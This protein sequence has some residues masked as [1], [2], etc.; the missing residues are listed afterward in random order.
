LTTTRTASPPTTG[1]LLVAHGSSEDPAASLPVR[2]LGLELR[3]SGRFAQVA[4]GFW[5]EWPGLRGAL[6]GLS[7]DRAV[8]VPVFM[9]KGWFTTH[10]VPRELGLDVA[11]ANR[12]GP[13]EVRVTR[14]IGASE[15]MSELVEA[16]ALE[17]LGEAASQAAVVVAG[18]GTARSPRSGDSVRQV[19]EALRHRGRFG[20]VE[21][22]F[23]E[24]APGL[25]EV[26]GALEADR[27]LVVPF[28][29]ADGPH[30]AI[31]MA[32]AIGLPAHPDDQPIPVG[33]RTMWL[34]P[35]VG[36][37]QCIADLVIKLVTDAIGE[38]LAHNTT[39]RNPHTTQLL[40]TVMSDGLL[41]QVLLSRQ[42]DT[43]D[44]RH[45]EDT[46]F[47][48]TQLAEFTIDGLL[49]TLRLDADGRYRPNPYAPDLRRG[50]V[51]RL[52]DAAA[53]A[54]AVEVIYPG[55]LANLSRADVGAWVDT[56]AR[57]GEPFVR[58]LPADVERI[59]QAR[60]TSACLCV[61]R[62][63]YARTTASRAAS[64][65]SPSD[66]PAC[67]EPCPIFLAALQ[68]A[69]TPSSPPPDHA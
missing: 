41:G 54:E 29:V 19:V 63:E 25:A 49:E 27:V 56:A 9:A 7:T 34:T 50:W 47:P 31:D 11:G 43:F 53:A 35:S 45:M 48:D 55:L 52:S 44:L 21:A 28:L 36:T 65:R 58:A 32:T 68:H 24:Q 51:A 69:L 59:A 20:S 2:R 40:N 66:T 33:A 46:A 60:C 15:A 17:R 39:P 42:G 22:A 23:L 3:A 57:L 37:H 8:V 62:W 30:R 14:P 38:P 12:P 13:P 6:A 67:L 16:M 10:V 5:R 64:S 26:V 4:L 1:L 18:H 61:R